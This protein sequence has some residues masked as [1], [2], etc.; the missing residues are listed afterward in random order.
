MLKQLAI[1]H[2]ISEYSRVTLFPP[3]NP[4]KT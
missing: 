1:T 3:Q 4:Y 2:Q